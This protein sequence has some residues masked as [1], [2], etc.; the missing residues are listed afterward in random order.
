MR[1]RLGRAVGRLAI[2][3]ALG[4]GLSQGVADDAR[5]HVVML[6]AEDEYQTEQTLPE[7]AHRY[8]EPNYRVTVLRGDARERHRI[9]GM[10]AIDT[11]NLVVVSVRRRALPQADLDRLRRYVAAG[12]PVLG[13]RT[14]NHAFVLRAGESPPAGTAVWPEFDAQVLG[15]HY[16]GH[17]KEVPDTTIAL[18][19]GAATHPIVRGV[20]V[21]SIMG[22]GT[23]YRVSPLEGFT[24]PLIMGTIPGEPPEPVLWVHRKPARGRVVYT[25]LG[26][27]GDFAQEGFCRMLS[28][29]ITWLIEP[30]KGVGKLGPAQAPGGL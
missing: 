7:F 25:S 24:L 27:P 22:K 12:K 13:I 21:E 29:A 4:T 17:H 9:P 8:L 10:E 26:H 19:P 1:G 18:V 5:P 30:E 3:I 23:L 11:A 28:Q 15:G 2:L 6:I 14:A 16:T 20:A